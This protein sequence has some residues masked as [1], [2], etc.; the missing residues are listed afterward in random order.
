VGNRADIVAKPQR[1][2]VRYV[3]FAYVAPSGEFRLSL[4]ENRCH[5]IDSD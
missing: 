1:D 4:P 2:G 3:D 5:L